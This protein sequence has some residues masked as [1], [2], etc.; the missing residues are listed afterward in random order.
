MQRI[1]VD[2]ARPDA[3]ALGRAAAVIRDGGLV[4]FPTDTLYGIAADPFNPVAVRR[5]FEAKHRETGSALPLVAADLTQVLA[6]IG[7][8]SVNARRLSECFW[9]GPLTILMPAPPAIAPEVAAGTGLV[10]VRVPNHVVARELCRLAGSPLVATSANRSGQPASS[11]P[12]DVA[13]SMGEAVDILVDSGPTAGGPASTI[14]DA[15][16]DA[17]RLVREGA[18]SWERIEECLRGRAQ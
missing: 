1:H 11:D 4:A 5:V 14:V 9:P 10:A 8:M 2:A 15:S 16:S 3:A 18:V 6:R 13:A 12:D 17:T 7:P